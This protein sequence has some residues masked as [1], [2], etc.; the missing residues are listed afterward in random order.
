MS[1]LAKRRISPSPKTRRALYREAFE[2]LDHA[3]RLLGQARVRH[4]AA[5]A[6]NAKR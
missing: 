6:R 3:Q 2:L 5:A 4:E 1:T